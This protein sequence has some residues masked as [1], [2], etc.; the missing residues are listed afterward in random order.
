VR[1][2][3]HGV[4]RARGGAVIAAAVALAA[5]IGAGCGGDDSTTEVQATPTGSAPSEQVV[6]QTGNGDFNPA[7]I[8]QRVS[9]GVVTIYSTFGSSD[10]LLSPGAA[11]G[12]GFVVSGDGEI[13]T[14]AHVV[15]NGGRA[16]GG[17][18]ISKADSVLVEFADR[19]RVPAKI[20]GFDPDADLA[21]LKVDTGD[22]TLHPLTLSDRT[23][24]AVGEPVAA[25]GAP[26]LQAESL[27]VGVVSATDRTIDSLTDF[28]IDNG[29][30]TDASVNPGNSGGPLLDSKGEVIGVTQQI[31]TESGS[32]SGVAFAIPVEAIHYSLP[33]LRESGNVEY[34]YLGVSSQEIWPQ[35]ADHLDLGSDTGVLLSKVI[36]GGPA[37]DAGLQGGSDRITFQGFP[38]D[39]G[40]D[41]IVAVDGERLVAKTDLAEL[42][43]RHRPGETVTLEIIRDG[44]RREVDVELGERPENPPAG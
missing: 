34:P 40:G 26:F 42:V 4:A 35:L 29:I 7:A 6:L 27:S 30:Q 39:S 36:D 43:A 37:D 10:S 5:A 41:L 21:L 22:V 9:P 20:V 17:G 18:E 31:A 25:I 24:F 44:E 16:N 12:T 32:N 13:V 19:N 2:L 23:T 3:L 28:A 8:Y 15:T 38:V 11:G 1:Y 14:N 33:Q